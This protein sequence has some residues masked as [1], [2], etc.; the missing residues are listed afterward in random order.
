MFDLLKTELGGAWEGRYLSEFHVCTLFPK[1]AKSALL[2][3]HLSPEFPVRTSCAF[4]WPFSI[5]GS[6]SGDCI[7]L[8]QVHCPYPDPLSPDSALPSVGSLDS[9]SKP[10]PSLRL[11]KEVTVPSETYCFALILQIFEALELHIKAL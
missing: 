9:E 2:T 8:C 4:T 1:I 6:N 5:S 10:S 11:L 3:P 7:T